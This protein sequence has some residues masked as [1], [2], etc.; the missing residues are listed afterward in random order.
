MIS[1]ADT[2]LALRLAGALSW[3]W[4]LRGRHSEGR[5]LLTMALA[6]TALPA[7]GTGPVTDR[8]RALA[9]SP[10][11]VYMIALAPT[12]WSTAERRSSSTPG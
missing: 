3:Y 11:W 7:D 10:P 9:S 12:R 1:Q 5:R 4:F 2:A 6:A 8:A